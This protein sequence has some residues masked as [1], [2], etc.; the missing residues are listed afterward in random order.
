MTAACCGASSRAMRRD[1]GTHP[2]LGRLTAMRSLFRR[3]R[4][5]QG[6]PHARRGRRQALAA[7]GALI[8]PRR[9][10]QAI[11]T[12]RSTWRERSSATRTSAEPQADP[13]SVAFFQMIYQVLIGNGRVALRLLRRALRRQRDARRSTRHWP[14]SWPL[15]LIWAAGKARATPTQSPA[16]AEDRSFLR[17]DRQTSASALAGASGTS[18]TE[19]VSGGAPK[20]PITAARAVSSAC[21]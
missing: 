12:R 2:E 4:A 18:A 17:H 19:D 16:T 8:Y 10:R 14:A 5:D 13:A 7:L 3:L 6:L 9:R 11:R 15:S 20:V 21:T 1:A